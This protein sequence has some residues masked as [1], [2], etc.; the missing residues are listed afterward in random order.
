M[1][2]WT[3]IKYG[4]HGADF[5]IHVRI[6]QHFTIGS[7]S[8][9]VRRRSMLKVGKIWNIFRNYWLLN[10]LG[11]QS[12]VHILIEWFDIGFLVSSKIL[13]YFLYCSMNLEALPFWHGFVDRCRKSQFTIPIVRAHTSNW[14]WITDCL[15]STTN[16]PDSFM[17]HT[18]PNVVA[19]NYKRG[20]LSH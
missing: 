20:M 19:L 10:D 14:S 16:R 15:S 17:N 12:S 18:N 3:Q 13:S 11:W 1:L 8:V 9:I 7:M 4:I 5:S 6:R 2:S